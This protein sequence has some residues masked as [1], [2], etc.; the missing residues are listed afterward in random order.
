MGTYEQRYWLND[1]WGMNRSERQSG[2]YHPYIPTMLM[3]Q[4]IVLTASASQAVAQAQADISLLN[5]RVQHL[6]GTEPLA[7]LILR[8]EAMAS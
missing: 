2:T 7:R 4:D 8:S 6:M 5:E 3:E 1:T